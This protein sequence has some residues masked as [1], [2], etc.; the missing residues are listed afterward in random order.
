M[1]PSQRSALLMRTTSAWSACD[2]YRVRGI[3]KVAGGK[4]LREVAITYDVF[5]DVKP[6]RSGQGCSVHNDPASAVVL[7][8]KLSR[9]SLAPTQQSGLAVLFGAC[10]TL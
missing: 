1:S 5:A 7:A 4:K 6:H 3:F 2:L 9:E 10:E 8:P